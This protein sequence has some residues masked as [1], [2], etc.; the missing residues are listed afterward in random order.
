[1]VKAEKLIR[2]EENAVPIIMSSI[3]LYLIFTTLYSILTGDKLYDIR[4]NIAIISS[5]IGLVLF[6]YLAIV[7]PRKYPEEFLKYKRHAQE[8]LDLRRGK[9]ALIVIGTTGGLLLLLF[10]FLFYQF[11]IESGDLLVFM[12]CLA[13]FSISIL[14]LYFIHILEK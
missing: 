6:I 2:L 12:I 13:S 11:G 1:V 10:I 9:I 7:F 5:L 3:F 14:G 8:N 4:A